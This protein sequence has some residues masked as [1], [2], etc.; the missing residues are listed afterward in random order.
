[1]AGGLISGMMNSQKKFKTG[2]FVQKD[3]NILYSK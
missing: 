2:A 3:E 1:M